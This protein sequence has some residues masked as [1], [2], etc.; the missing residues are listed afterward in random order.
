MQYANDLTA[1]SCGKLLVFN[2]CVC[3]NFTQAIFFF[4][5]IDNLEHRTTNSPKQPSVHVCVWTCRDFFLAVVSLLLFFK[6]E[7][8]AVYIVSIIYVSQNILPICS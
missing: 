5:R 4:T 7:W 6:I 8:F 2:I 3:V 1:A